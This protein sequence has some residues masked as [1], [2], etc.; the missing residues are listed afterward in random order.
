MPPSRWVIIKLMPLPW[1]TNLCW[2]RQHHNYGII[3]LYCKRLAPQEKYLLKPKINHRT[4][5][6][7]VSYDHCT[8]NVQSPYR[9][10]WCCFGVYVKKIFCSPC[11]QK[12][13]LTHQN[14][15]N[16]PFFAVLFH[17]LPQFELRCFHC[18]FL[19]T[20]TYKLYC[21]VQYT[22][23]LYGMYDVICVDFYFTSFIL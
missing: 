5:T 7:P 20:S 17:C 19:S 16:F 10:V 11:F 6:A 8:S 23:I 21:D 18:C 9:R 2:K 4:S 22:M 14:C 15:L 13:I 3:Y 1:G 12:R